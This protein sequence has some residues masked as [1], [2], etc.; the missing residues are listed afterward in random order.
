MGTLGK[1][2]SIFVVTTILGCSILGCSINF[3]GGG[4]ACEV[5]GLLLRRTGI[6][7]LSP[8]PVP[9]FFHFFS[10]SAHY[11]RGILLKPL[12]LTAFPPAGVR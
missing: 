9:K 3:C 8:P 11:K 4:C 6:V 1:K 5:I 7:A 10:T 2:S 12:T